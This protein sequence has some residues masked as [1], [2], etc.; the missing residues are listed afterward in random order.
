MNKAAQIVSETLLGVYNRPVTLGKREFK[1]YQ[2]AIREIARMFNGSD[3]SV[4]DNMKSLQVMASMPE[5]MDS[6]CHTLAVAVTIKRPALERLA[7]E[8]IRRFATI[9]QIQEAIISLGSVIRG[10]DIFGNCEIDKSSV[11]ETTKV[12]GNNNLTGQIATFIDQLHLS[13]QEVYEKLSFPLLLL[14]MADK[15]RVVYDETDT[16]ETKTLSGKEM[17]KMKKGL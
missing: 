11:K 2:P 17:L 6:L 10:E 8:Y 13:Y 16:G 9:D 12:L 14:M 4:N 15:P 1:I 7:F 5:H 3:L